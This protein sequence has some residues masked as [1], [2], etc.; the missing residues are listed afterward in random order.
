M[1]NQITLV[2][3]VTQDLIIKEYSD[4]K[5]VKF[6]IAVKEFSA[7]KDE[8]KTMF[9][10]V[11]AWNGLGDRALQIVT[12]GREIVVM[13]RLGINEYVTQIN[14]QA[15]KKT[16]PFVKLTSFHLCGSKPKA[17]EPDTDEHEEE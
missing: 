2:G 15:V 6:S 7:N 3:R 8:E 14:G 1:N 10:N 11:D 16:K 9:I 4:N 13:G 17:D 5:V 12:K